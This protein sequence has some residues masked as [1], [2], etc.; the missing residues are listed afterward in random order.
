M[1]VILLNGKGI[2]Q[3]TAFRSRQAKMKLEKTPTPHDLR[4]T[5]ITL[6]LEGKAPLQAVQYA[7]RH[8]DPRTTEHYQRRKFTLDDNAVD[9]IHS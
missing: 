9:S 8:K 6:A 4:A 2:E 3:L 7:A 1:V 5:F